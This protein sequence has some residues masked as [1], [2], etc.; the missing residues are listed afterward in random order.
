MRKT[1]I[2]PGEIHHIYNRGVN[3]G[4][5]FFTQD[6]WTFFLR[7]LREFFGPQKAEIIAYCLM[8]NHFHLLVKALIDDFG[9]QVMQPFSVSYTKAINKQE[10]RVGSL[11]QGPFQNRLVT[12]DGDLIHLSRYLHLNP[13]TAG[14]VKRPEQWDFSSYQDYTSL[15]DGTL[16][17]PDA[18][19]CHFPSASAYAEFVNEP[20]LP[21]AKIDIEL[22]LD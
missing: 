17:K 9:K 5:I 8:P 16:P 21:D 15:R 4:D 7:R 1:P 11:F 13:A 3:Y 19:L 20:L 18:V 22:L 2:Y 6:N 12:K 10:A 14:F